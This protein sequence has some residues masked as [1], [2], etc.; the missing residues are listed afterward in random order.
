MTT[1]KKRKIYSTTSKP[2]EKLTKAEKR[3]TIAKDVLLQ[4]KAGLLSFESFSYL[5]TPSSLWYKCDMELKDILPETES[6][7]YV[8]AKG[9]LFISDIMR[10]DECTL[11]D[12]ENSSENKMVSRLSDIFDLFQLDLI[13]TSYECD[14]INDHTGRLRCSRKLSKAIKFGLLFPSKT[15]RMIAIMNNI[16]K[17]NGTFKP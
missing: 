2:F 5:S 7:C 12:A 9:A 15:K 17:N 13:E 8:C 14:I 3:V 4:L 11:R 6:P 10:R 1:I 16:I